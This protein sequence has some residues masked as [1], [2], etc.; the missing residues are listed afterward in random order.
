[1]LIGCACIVANSNG[2]RASDDRT[3][4]PETLDGRNFA[5]HFGERVGISFALIFDSDLLYPYLPGYC[6]DS[7]GKTYQKLIHPVDLSTHSEGDFS[8]CLRR[9]MVVHGKY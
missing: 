3:V 1:M 8:R 5:S 2:F 4:R 9:F 6:P 7:E